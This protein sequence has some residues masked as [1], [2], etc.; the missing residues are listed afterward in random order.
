MRGCGEGGNAR[1]SEE[2]DANDETRGDR[3]SSATA[4]AREAAGEKINLIWGNTRLDG[5]RY[6]LVGVGHRRRHVCHPL[7]PTA[8]ASGT[9]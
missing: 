8:R 3:R 9:R 1:V 7:A 5:R 6:A 2:V 4:D